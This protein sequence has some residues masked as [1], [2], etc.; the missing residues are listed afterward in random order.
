M[1]LGGVRSYFVTDDSTQV[2]TPIFK[3]EAFDT[4]DCFNLEHGDDNLYRKTSNEL[5]TTPSSISND[6]R[7][8]R[9]AIKFRNLGRLISWFHSL[10]FFE[11][12]PTPPFRISSLHLS[13]ERTIQITY[14]RY[15]HLR[16]FV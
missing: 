15:K 14:A 7:S 8:V 1:T 13:S 2:I 4:I 16:K 12:T 10:R 9:A 5:P 11:P 3:G 6:R